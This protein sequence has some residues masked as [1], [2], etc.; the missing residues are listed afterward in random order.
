MQSRPL[1]RHDGPR[2]V[3]T[4]TPPGFAALRANEPQ[5]NVQPTITGMAQQ[6]LDEFNQRPN[7]RSKIIARLIF[8]QVALLVM[9]APL[10]FWPAIQPSEIGLLAVGLLLYGVTFTRN[11]THK[12][13][14]A[15]NLLIVSSGM[16]T[17]AGVGVQFIAQSDHVLAVS[18]ASL[19]FILTI[20]EA[21]LLLTS[22]RVLVTTAATTAFT[23]IAIA[24]ALM[25]GQTN[26]SNSQAYLLAVMALGLQS[27]AGMIAWQVARFI[28][29]YAG[30]VSQAR[31]EDFIASQ[32]EAYRRSSEEQARV[33]HEQATQLAQVI[34]S[35]SI[36]DYTARIYLPEGE[37]RPVA[38]VVNVLGEELGKLIQEQHTNFNDSEAARILAEAADAIARGEAAPQLNNPVLNATGGM[39]QGALASI[40]RLQQMVQLRMGRIRDLSVDAGLRLKQIDERSIAVQGTVNE[41]RQKNGHMR[42][43]A[44]LLAESAARLN[45]LLDT[46]LEALGS[47]LPS[48]VRAQAHITTPEASD[49]ELHHILP[50]VTVQFETIT[51]ETE[52]GPEDVVPVGGV[53][54]PP[55]ST[56]NDPIAQAKLREAWR[57]IIE[58]TEEVAKQ[59]RDSAVLVEGLGADSKSLRTL[60]DEMQNSRQSMAVV[61]ALAQQI[62]TLA[63]NPTAPISNAQMTDALATGYTPPGGI[64][65]QSLVSGNLESLTPTRSPSRPIHHPVPPDVANAGDAPANS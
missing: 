52:L 31:R 21:G 41:N 25:I 13:A 3:D 4:A 7:R 15:Q 55:V 49:T 5:A 19:P 54:T 18:L 34:M 23:T 50:G 28:Q 61:R 48:E 12:I 38:D 39:V 47:L 27:L 33:L 24:S 45:K 14:Q 37:L 32:F 1:D 11:Q 6:Q 44:E 22:E 51:D 36:R 29:D 58:M 43:Q 62:Y 57:Q 40:R 35:L 26:T 60:A 65:A 46:T 2:P 9:T 53:P 17:A 8:L 20:I 10:A 56:L 59:I 63:N 64:N 30:Q 42:S 16:V